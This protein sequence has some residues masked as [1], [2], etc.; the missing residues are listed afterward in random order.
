MRGRPRISRAPTSKPYLV[1]RSQLTHDQS[2]WRPAA[3][4]GGTFWNSQAT[5]LQHW[6]PCC[7]LTPPSPLP[8]DMASLGSAVDTFLYAPA[9]ATTLSATSILPHPASGPFTLSCTTELKITSATTACH[10]PT[11]YHPRE[12]V[13]LDFL[14]CL[15]PADRRMVAMAYARLMHLSHTIESPERLQRNPPPPTIFESALPPPT[16]GTCGL[17]PVHGVR[18]FRSNNTFA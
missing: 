10:P 8:Q 12:L 4:A 1:H 9:S 17:Y 15:H 16:M 6:I 14:D 5:A 11:D 7:P 2:E 13:G 3:V 18:I